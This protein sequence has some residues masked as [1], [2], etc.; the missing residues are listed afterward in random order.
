LERSFG[1]ESLAAQSS[2]AILVLFVMTALQVV[3]GELMPKSIALQFP[4]ST[5]LATYRP[6]RWS[7]AAY[8]AFIWL[9][10]GS[11][12]L[13]LRPFGVAPGAHMHVHSS[14]ELE[15]LFAESHRGG[16]L[17]PE[18]H[19]RLQR[20]LRLSRRSVRQLMVPRSQL[21]AIEA[22]TPDDEIMRKVL[23]SAYS[24]LPVYQDTIDNLIGSLNT[25]DIVASYVG[26]GKLP[27]LKS[28][29][30]PIPFVPE[31][32]T[33][34]HLV[35]LLRQER[36]SKAIVVDE[37]GGVQGMISIDDLLVELFGDLGDELKASNGKAEVLP[38][39]QVKLR[40]SMR[41]DA[42]LEW[43]GQPWEGSAATLGGLI[44][45][46]L[47]RLPTRGERICIG[48]SEVTVLEVTPTSIVTI[49][50]RPVREEA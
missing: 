47:G 30:R 42:A 12:A 39:G 13:L 32:L 2:A 43:I 24:R 28:L 35:R 21:D 34:D 20:G 33:A 36:T 3:L 18:M 44:V 41:P 14:Q 40:G 25:K 10:N 11:A 49:A 48:S 17:T 7:V 23:D 22:S 5:A 29:V 31:T 6:M 50:V 15:L 26:G 8:A 19:Q 46:Q 38:D 45:D 27:P 16:V 9:L 37:Y 1:L 4:E